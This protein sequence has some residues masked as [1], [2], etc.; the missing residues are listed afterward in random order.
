M[1]TMFG[2]KVFLQLWVKVREN[3]SDDDGLLRQLGY[4]D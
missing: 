3:W 1:E 2:G 4:M